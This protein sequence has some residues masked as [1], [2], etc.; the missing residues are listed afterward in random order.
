MEEMNTKRYSHMGV[1]FS[2]GKL[3]FVYVFGGRGSDDE[4]ICDAEKYSL[5]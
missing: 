4:T 3:E 2:M 1:Y 5:C